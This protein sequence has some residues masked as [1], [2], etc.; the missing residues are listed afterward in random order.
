MMMCSR[1]VWCA[2]A[3]CATS[4][5]GSSFL[6]PDSHEPGLIAHWVTGSHAVRDG[7]IDDVT[8]SF[9]AT[10]NG[11]PRIETIGPLEATT[12]NG[13]TDWLI[14]ADDVATIVPRLPARAMTLSAWVNLR[15]SHKDGGIISAVLDNGPLE[16][17]W[18]LGYDEEVFVFGLSTKG[19]DDG[20]GRLTYLRGKT[21][22]EFGRWYHVAATYDGEQMRLYVNG[23]AD[24]VGVEQSG[25]ILYPSGTPLAL[26]AY[27]DTNE[28]NP[29]EGSI[30]EVKIHNVVMPPDKIRAV[31]EKHANVISWRPPPTTQLTFLVTP[32]LQFATQDSIRVLCETT[33]PAVMTVEYGET[34]ALG[35]A[36]TATDARL[37][38]EVLL[39]G[40]KPQT[41]YLYRVVC[42]D[43]L[44]NVLTGPLLTFQTA[45][46][47]DSPFAFTVIGDTQ[48]NPQVT[49]RVNELAYALRPNFQLHCGDVVDD[50]H[51]KS[52]WLKDLLEPSSVLMSHVPMYPVIGN[53]E[54][55][56]HWYYDYFSLPHPEYYYTFTFGNAQFFMLDSNK[57]F[58]P[59]SEQY[60]WLERE[61]GSSQAEW[62]FACHHH[63][64]FSSDSDDYG[65]T[66]KGPS[67]WGD[68]N[69]RKLVDLYERFGI[70]V[71][72]NGHIHVYE[73]TWPIYRMKIDPEKGVRYITSGGG[74][75]GLEK[76]APQRTWFS[77]HFN[78]AHHFCYV[79]IHH[80][81][82]QFKAY[83]VEGRLFDVF[84]MTKP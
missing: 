76:A 66:M 10:V 68:S 25:D 55:N 32:Y 44:G 81:T 28:R 4:A 36:V 26:G 5:L 19:A 18:V 52:Q 50:G 21:K 11:S 17:G 57:D 72:F 38:S 71:A 74:G 49:R 45:V 9:S 82:I 77:L 65:D 13:L 42:R 69:A 30:Y 41:H 78:P 8:H 23:A 7:R 56:S 40:L 51:A 12:L 29:L 27:V 62:K 39:T 60:Q 31:A 34:S 33:R 58:S 3:V 6:H 84:E 61:L 83:D 1:R 67:L 16:K 48:R 64:C 14:V 59:G 80:K 2:A 43:D 47:P 70:D 22:F 79:T 46:L 15:A 37:I 63:P 54:E 35:S 73:R 53:H 24:A 75:G 20:D